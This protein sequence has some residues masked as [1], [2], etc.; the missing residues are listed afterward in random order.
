MVIVKKPSIVE[1]CAIPLRLLQ[2]ALNI[3]PLVGLWHI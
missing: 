2:R 3:M 1:T